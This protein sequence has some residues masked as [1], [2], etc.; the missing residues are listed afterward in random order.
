MS[1]DQTL[2]GFHTQSIPEYKQDE[3]P[4]DKQREINYLRGEVHTLTQKTSEYER[5]IRE[6]EQLV[7]TF[8]GDSKANVFKIDHALYADE[9]DPLVTTEET[10]RIAK[11][12][13]QPEQKRRG[14]PRKLPFMENEGTYF[15]NLPDG[16]RK[17]VKCGKVYTYLS[18]VYNHYRQVHAAKVVA[19]RSRL[20]T[21]KEELIKVILNK[22]SGRKGD[23]H[24]R[25][26]KLKYTKLPD[27]KF[28]CDSCDPE[29]PKRFS[30]Y[31]SFYIHYRSAHPEEYKRDMELVSD[32]ELEETG[33]PLAE[34]ELYDSE[35]LAKQA[36]EENKNAF[37]EPD[38]R[39]LATSALNAASEKVTDAR[40]YMNKKGGIYYC[41]NCSFNH[42]T[43]AMVV[44]H[45]NT[46]HN[47]RVQ[48]TDDDFED[49]D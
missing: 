30:N 47:I 48:G 10:E 21:S 49:Q 22:K 46:N 19:A 40:G 28:R 38:E 32:D 43:F 41:S 2:S 16:K 8:Q 6:L 11:A 42:P 26:K 25:V 13:Y 7:R 37:Q 34:N 12:V 29:F 23:R 35:M 44:L 18:G 39:Q 5:R 27:N 14:R 31:P 33:E 4:V 36:E 1:Y 45:L 24:G 3:T 15:I 9:D 17:C 20:P